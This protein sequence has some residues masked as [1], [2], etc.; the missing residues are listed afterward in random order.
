MVI[1]YKFFNFRSIKTTLKN[2]HYDD[3]K[4]I[5]FDNFCEVT[6]DLKVVFN[7]IHNV[8]P[9]IIN[10][11]PNNN[12]I[13]ISSFIKKQF[14]NN[15]LLD[16]DQSLERVWR[17]LIKYGYSKKYARDIILD[18]YYESETKQ[19]KFVSDKRVVTKIAL[20]NIY[21]NQIRI[22]GF[23]EK[24]TYYPLFIDI[25]HHLFVGKS[26]DFEKKEINQITF[27][28]NVFENFN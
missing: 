21:N 16:T 15:E 3:I 11:I 9:K 10:K 20:K 24:T 18:G 2:F 26:S 14:S 6:I 19:N 13:D 5:N 12:N 27:V 8:I 25:N 7:E 22:M 28:N 23:F 17:V 4:N 1:N